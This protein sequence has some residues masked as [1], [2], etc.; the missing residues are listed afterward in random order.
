MTV[1]NQNSW[2]YKIQMLRIS[3]NLK[4]TDQEFVH[5]LSDDRIMACV[6]TGGPN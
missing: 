1:F 6:R 5:S 3:C 4:A 2:T